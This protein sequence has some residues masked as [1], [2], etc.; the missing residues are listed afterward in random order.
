HKPRGQGGYQSLHKVVRETGGVLFEIQIRSKEMH[1]RAERGSAAHW[2]YKLGGT[3][4]DPELVKK[5][6][7]L[8]EALEKTIGIADK[9]RTCSSENFSEHGLK[10]NGRVPGIHVFTPAGDVILLP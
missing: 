8:R 9:S 7:T 6:N 5:I 2:I 10:E 4:P 1:L 3:S